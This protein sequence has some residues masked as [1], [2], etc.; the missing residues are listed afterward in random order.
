V[1]QPAHVDDVQFI[2]HVLVAKL[3]YLH[4]GSRG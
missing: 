3:E 1:E 4:A 2:K